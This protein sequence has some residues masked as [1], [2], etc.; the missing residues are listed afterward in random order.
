MREKTVYRITKYVKERENKVTK[1]K[2]AIERMVYRVKKRE[3][4]AYI[5]TKGEIMRERKSVLDNK[6]HKIYK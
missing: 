5:L 1:G 2:R 4:K 6:G 3:K